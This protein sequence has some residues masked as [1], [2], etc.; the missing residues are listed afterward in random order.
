MDIVYAISIGMG[1]LAIL[2]FMCMP[3]ADNRPRGEFP[4]WNN[5]KEDK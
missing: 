1:C 5:G 2:A 3:R 4:K